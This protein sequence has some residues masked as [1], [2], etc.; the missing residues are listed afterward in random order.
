ME[1]NELVKKAHSIQTTDTSDLVE[2]TDYD[3]KI[4]EIKRKILNR[5]HDKYIIT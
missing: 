1:Y 4:N 2:K 3:T 5:N